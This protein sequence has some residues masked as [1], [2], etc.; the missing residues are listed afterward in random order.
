MYLMGVKPWESAKWEVPSL[1]QMSG[2]VRR[3]LEEANPQI[4]AS[5]E[6]D[7]REGTDGSEKV[8]KEEAEG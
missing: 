4:A 3:A 7:A 6:R 8:T 1:D 5:A 2:K